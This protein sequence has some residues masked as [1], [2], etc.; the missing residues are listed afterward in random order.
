MGEQS[1]KGTGFDKET[2]SIIGKHFAALV[3]HAKEKEGL[4]ALAVYIQIYGDDNNQYK[5]NKISSMKNGTGITA[6]DVM[7]IQA[8]KNLSLDW[9]M[10]GKGDPPPELQ[11]KKENTD[12]DLEPGNT[13]RGFLSSLMCLSLAQ[14]VYDLNLKIK[15]QD[16]FHHKFNIS[17]SIEPINDFPDDD[18]PPHYWQNDSV[19]YLVQGLRTLASYNLFSTHCDNRGLF[20]LKGN[21]YTEILRAIPPQ[22][23]LLDYSGGIDDQTVEHFA[24]YNEYQDDRFKIPQNYKNY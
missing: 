17:F 2:Q 3:D 6:Y 4:T 20:K 7:K 12:D 14:Y 18:C 23:Y 13:V 10:L 21:K 19:S 22:R 15:T 11:G 16:Y 9:L 5:E 24:Y 1:R 8:W